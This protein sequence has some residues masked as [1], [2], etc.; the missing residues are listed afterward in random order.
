MLKSEH[1]LIA[2]TAADGAMAANPT[3]TSDITSVLTIRNLHI[4]AVARES[5]R[6]P[7]L[8]FR[9]GEK[10]TLQTVDHGDL[11]LI[12]SP[13]ARH[14]KGQGKARG[15]WPRMARCVVVVLDSGGVGALAD[16]AEYGDGPGVNTIGNTALHIGGLALPHFERLGLGNLTSIAGVRAQSHPRARVARLKEKS[17]GKDTITGHWEMM[18]IVT[19]VPFP[20]YP[21]G[22]PPEVVEEFARITGKV[23]LGNKT[24]SG[25]EIIEELGPEHMA[26]GRPILYTSADSVFQVAAHE[27]I[28]PLDTLYDWC[29]RARAMLVPP[30]NV[31]RVI[32][33]PFVGEPR[34]FTRTANRRDYAI[35]P[36]PCLLDELAAN[37]VPVHAVG[38]ISDIFCGHGIA[39]SVRVADNAEAMQ[40]TFELLERVDRGFI[41]TNLNDFDSKYGHRRNVRGYANA[42][43]ELDA[44]IPRLEALLKPDDCA[45]FTAD[46]GCDPTAPGTD[47][48]RE[49]VPFVCLT[50]H[51]GADLGTIEGLDTVGKTVRDALL[52]RAA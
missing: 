46:H 45:I 2:A 6:H 37:G 38:K 28:V 48:T 24:A 15:E 27:D 9:D 19:R 43:Q 35:E 30:H 44:T 23:P 10:R 42:L 49:Y 25:T 52:V 31:N 29:E 51:P 26:T 32:A 47:H 1:G 40:R 11:V 12:V 36:P 41:F 8:T 5:S 16:A 33:R 18:G 14:R 7:L 39:T 17:R 3:A 20:T 22:F 50:R 34:A 4:A 13:Q 21:H